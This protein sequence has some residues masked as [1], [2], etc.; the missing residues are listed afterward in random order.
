MKI[1]HI[2]TALGSGGAEAV[3][4]QLASK[5]KKN[6]HIVISLTTLG[7]YGPIL[8]SNGIQTYAIEF[9]KGKLSIKGLIELYQIFKYHHDIDLIQTWMYHSDLIG[10]IY[11]LIFKKPIFWGIHNTELKFGKSSLSSIII[12]KICAKLSKKIPIKIICCAESAKKHHIE[13]GYDKEK[14]IT[15]PN[16]YDL[17]RFRY[18]EN[19]RKKILEE[20]EIKNNCVIFSMIARFDPYKD[21]NNLL[22][23]FSRINKN[24]NFI[25]ILTGEGV[26]KSNES[27]IKTIKKYNLEKNTILTGQRNDVEA[28]MNA[29]DFN[30]LSSS[31]E[32]FPN[33]LSESMACGTP[34]ISTDVGDAK[35]IIG[36]FG[37]IVPPQSPKDLHA[38]IEECIRLK[39]SNNKDLDILIRNCRSHIV[40][41]F[42]IDGMIEKYN[43]AWN[44]H[45][46]NY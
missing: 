10:S 1:L 27:L 11:S 24:S 16:G 45:R 43:I 38:A 17:D 21:H 25:L 28:I 36:Q 30:V 35:L 40:K 37:W 34:C 32:A 15:I 5:D 33:V 19:Q 46:I 26:N 18:C 22:N 39:N 4:L 3:L 13:I 20:F 7:K 9:P 44:G 2:I 31:S 29:A 14:F 8:K 12:S 42:S 23:A 41:N 6:Q